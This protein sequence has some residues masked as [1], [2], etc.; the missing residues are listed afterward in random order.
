MLSPFDRALKWLEES[1]RASNWENMRKMFQLLIAEVINIKKMKVVWLKES[2]LYYFE[3]RMFATLFIFL[4]F[5][6]AGPDL[7]IPLPI[8][9]IKGSLYFLSGVRLFVL[10]LQLFRERLSEKSARDNLNIYREIREISPFPAVIR[11]KLIN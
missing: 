5:G 10:Y 1:V 3:Q 11:K 6:G 2:I 7:N 4:Q 8:H 9:F